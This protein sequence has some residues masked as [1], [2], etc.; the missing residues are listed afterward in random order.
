MVTHVTTVHQ[1]NL[2]QIMMDPTLMVTVYVMPVMQNLIVQ[3]MIQMSVAYVLEIILSEPIV[4]V[5][6]MVMIQP[7]E[8]QVISMVAA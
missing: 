5:S 1:E 7:V 4:V 3:V 6:Q 8:L 2:I